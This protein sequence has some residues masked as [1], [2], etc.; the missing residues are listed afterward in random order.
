MSDGIGVLA[1]LVLSFVVGA[2][3]RVLRTL[4][5]NDSVLIGLDRRF[6]TIRLIALRALDPIMITLGLFIA[7]YLY[8]QALPWSAGVM[9]LLS[10]WHISRIFL[11]R[12]QAERE[13][14]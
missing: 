13:F 11:A 14:P 10:L 7:Y 2:L 6:V 9:L 12:V 4:L 5:V 1:L 8:E 3:L